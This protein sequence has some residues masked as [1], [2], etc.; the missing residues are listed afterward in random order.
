MHRLTAH[1]LDWIAYD[2]KGE[3]EPAARDGDVLSIAAADD[4]VTEGAFIGWVTSHGL[5][6]AGA[7]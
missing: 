6:L 1:D 5:R 7:C 2:E 4:W 3:R